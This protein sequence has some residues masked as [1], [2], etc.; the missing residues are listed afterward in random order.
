MRGAHSKYQDAL[1]RK[2]QAASDLDKRA[3]AKRKAADEIKTLLAKKATLAETA[4]Q[5]ARKLDL[6]IA[7]LQKVN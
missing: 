4:A 6:E 5:D 1:E 3:A 7:E 2:R